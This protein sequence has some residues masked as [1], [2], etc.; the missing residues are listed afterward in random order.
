MIEFDAKELGR[1][2]ERDIWRGKRWVGFRLCTR[3]AERT[4]VR[5]G[6]ARNNW[7][8]SAGEPDRTVKPAPGAPGHMPLLAPM[9]ETPPG[10]NPDVPIYITNNLP[11]I[12]GLEQGHS[13]LAPAGMVDV[14]LA[15]FEGG[16]LWD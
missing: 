10:G 7:A 5:T 6:T 15:E 4:P 12:V 11:Y 3:I 1:I 2:L 14:T 9:A 8:W 13:R 16:L